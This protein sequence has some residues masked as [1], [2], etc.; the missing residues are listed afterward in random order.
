MTR[1]IIQ[2]VFQTVAGN[3]TC[4]GNL[5]ALCDDGNVWCFVGEEWIKLPEIPQ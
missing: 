4:N 5:V 1:K 3:N 2:L